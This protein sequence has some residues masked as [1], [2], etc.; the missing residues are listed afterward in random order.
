VNNGQYFVQGLISVSLLMDLELVLIV[1]QNRELSAHIF[2]FQH[3]NFPANFVVLV[4]SLFVEIDK[5]A[6][7]R[8]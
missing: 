2:V 3:W 5:C 4:E 8:L 1:K 7:K 6:N